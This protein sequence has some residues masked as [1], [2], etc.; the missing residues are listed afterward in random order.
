M[1]SSSIDL[2]IFSLRGNQWEQ[3]EFDS[4]LP[5]KNTASSNGGPRVGSFLNGSIH[6]LVYDNKTEMDVIIAFDL[7]EMTLSEIAL[8]DGFYSDYSTRICDLMV[9]DRLISVWSMER[10]RLGLR[11]LIFLFTL[12]RSFPQYALQ[13]VVILL[14]QLMVD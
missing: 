12:I 10:S 2:E 4:D 1:V 6:W 9:F 5:Y 11:L 3:I 7:K 13:I 14:D 8:P